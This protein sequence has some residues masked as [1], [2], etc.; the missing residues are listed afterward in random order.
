MQKTATSDNP[1]EKVSARKEERRGQDRR[2]ED[3]GE[4]VGE[5]FFIQRVGRG[6]WPTNA[7]TGG[8]G[9][10]GNLI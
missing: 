7:V 9:R 2:V 10:R 4:G 6:R 3:A 5:S 1:R 8:R